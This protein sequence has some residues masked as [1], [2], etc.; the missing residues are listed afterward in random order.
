MYRTARHVETNSIN[1][2]IH[3]RALRPAL[4]FYLSEAFIY[5]AIQ[6]LKG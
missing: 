6:N 4:I 3:E 1:R 5:K 2:I